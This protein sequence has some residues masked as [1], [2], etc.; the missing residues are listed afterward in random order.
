[1]ANKN[2]AATRFG[3]KTVKPLGS[4]PDDKSKKAKAFSKIKTGANLVPYE[5]KKTGK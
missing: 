2:D 5:K 1:M 3:P 4:V